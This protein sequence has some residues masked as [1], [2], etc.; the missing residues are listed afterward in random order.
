MKTQQDK[1]ECAIY[2]HFLFFPNFFLPFEE[3]ST[4]QVIQSHYCVVCFSVNSK[5]FFRFS[6][7]QKGASGLKVVNSVVLTN[8]YLQNKC[9]FSK[10]RK[11]LLKALW[12]KETMLTTSILSFSYNLL[13]YYIDLQFQ[14]LSGS[15][16]CCLLLGLDLTILTFNLLSEM[17]LGLD[18][19]IL[20]FN[21]LSE[22]LLG[23]DLTILTFNLLSEMLLGLDLTI[24]TFNLLS[25]M[26][27]GL[28]LTILTFNRF[29]NNKF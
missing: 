14:P 7:L 24:L 3:K 27:L 20:T 2:Q 12:E 5:Q 21:L 15:E 23:L 16:I 19:T 26:L 29:P 11:K 9:N 28:Y 4:P 13:Y 17:L 10:F 25:E 1:R 6:T 22:M 8:S 18:L